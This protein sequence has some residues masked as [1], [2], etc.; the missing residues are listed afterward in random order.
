MSVQDTEQLRMPYTIEDG[1]ITLTRV[2]NFVNCAVCGQV[3]ALNNN[4][5]VLIKT[6]ATLLDAKSNKITLRCG[7]C[8][9]FNTIALDAVLCRGNECLI[10]M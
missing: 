8:K 1:M 2:S 9:S 10:A 7:R 6:F 4:G 5:C 3:L